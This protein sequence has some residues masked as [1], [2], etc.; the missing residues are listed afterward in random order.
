MNFA[1]YRRIVVAVVCG[2]SGCSVREPLDSA[3]DTEV[4]SSDGGPASSSSTTTGPGDKPVPPPTSTTGPDDTTGPVVTTVLDTG[5]PV[6]SVVTSDATTGE[7]VH[8]FQA[9]LAI[10]TV[11]APDLPFQFIATSTWTGWPEPH[12]LR[13]E[14]Q[15]LALG[16]NEVLTPRTPIGE[17][18]VFEA[19]PVVDGAFELDMGLT[20]VTGQAN[21]ITGG[22]VTA[23]LLLRG[24]LVAPDFYCGQVDGDIVTPLEASVNGSTFAALAM[25]GPD[26]LPP[27]VMITCDGKTV[28]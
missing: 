23:T 22:D 14:L 11:I 3:S 18:I 25:A 26:E 9:L 7:A 17:P 16:L 1:L 2:S 24:S 5:D 8:E 27:L 19:I 20:M 10:S 6:T 4:G 15:P 13:L 28:G 21:P 12:S